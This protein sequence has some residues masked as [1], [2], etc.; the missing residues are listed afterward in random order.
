[1]LICYILVL[2]INTLSEVEACCDVLA[3]ITYI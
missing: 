3:N 2:S 1:M